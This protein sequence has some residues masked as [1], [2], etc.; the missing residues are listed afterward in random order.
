MTYYVN[1]IDAKNKPGTIELELDFR[2]DCSE[3]LIK[4]AEAIEA[5]TGIKR[6]VIVSA[7]P[8][9]GIKE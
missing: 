9:L 3:N 2:I 7:T 4:C 1:F 6:V 8:D 5:K